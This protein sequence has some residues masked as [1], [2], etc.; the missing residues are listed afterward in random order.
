MVVRQLA[1]RDYGL[2]QQII[3]VCAH[4][5]MKLLE[6]GDEGHAWNSSKTEARQPHKA[7]RG[8]DEHNHMVKNSKI[9]SPMCTVPSRGRI[10][11]AQDLSGFNS[12]FIGRSQDVC[13]LGPFPNVHTFFMFSPFV[14]RPVRVQVCLKRLALNILK[15]LN[16]CWRLDLQLRSKWWRIDGERGR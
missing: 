1:F 8:S 13:S 7:L 5:R 11:R 14:P 9:I 6:T 4:S 15:W 3:R 10:N 2:D 16:H 12:P